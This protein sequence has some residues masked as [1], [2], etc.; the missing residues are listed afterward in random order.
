MEIVWIEKDR[1]TLCGLCIPICVRRILEEREGTVV[2]TDQTQCLH[3]VVSRR[4]PF[5]KSFFSISNGTFEM[6]SAIRSP[7]LP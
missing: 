4:T 7:E 6:R 2:V 3:D 1:C 5:R